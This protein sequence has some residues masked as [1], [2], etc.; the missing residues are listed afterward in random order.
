MGFF[1]NLKNSFQNVYNASGFF[2]KKNSPTILLIGGIIASAAAVIL[3]VK[4][5][6]EAESYLP[7]V[8]RKIKK[9]KDEMND[10][11]LVRNKIVDI[12]ENKKALDKVY[13]QTS[14]KLVKTYAPALCLYL[15]AIGCFIGG[16]TVLNNRLTALSSAYAALNTAYF[17]Y[18][19]RVKSKIGNDAESDLFDGV[20]TE[21]TE[22]VDENGN[23]QIVK[24]KVKRYPSGSP[25]AVMWDESVQSWEPNGAMNKAWLEMI[26][27]NLNQLLVCKKYVFLY[28][29]YKTLGIEENM[30]SDEQLQASRVVGWIYDKYAPNGD[31]Y[32][33]IGIR[34]R[35][36]GEYT[37]KALAMMRGERNILLDFNVDGDILTGDHGRRKF[38]DAIRKRG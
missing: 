32:I 30:L 16:Q 10:D 21:K 4:E 38:S 20:V 24:Q 1:S 27:N 12:K 7:K 37:P 13:L 29:V 23:K 25:Y 17:N 3:A 9:L 34:N 11:N 35:A 22:V 8:R 14:A 33:T 36:T 19:E 26:E 5:T 2:V 18:R 28:E 31:N 15:I 6:K